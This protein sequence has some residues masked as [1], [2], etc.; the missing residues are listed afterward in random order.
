MNT[1]I[2]L[3]LY[4][5]DDARNRGYKAG[6]RVGISCASGSDRNLVK[7][8]PRVAAVRILRERRINEIQHIDIEVNSQ[9]SVRQVFE[10]IDSR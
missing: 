2:R 7:R 3:P 6:N 4:A 10:G 1:P 5:A 8:R 9:R